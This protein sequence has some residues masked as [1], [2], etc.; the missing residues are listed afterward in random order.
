MLLGSVAD[1]KLGDVGPTRVLLARKRTSD[2]PLIFF[3]KDVFLSSGVQGRVGEYLRVEGVVT[4][5]H[6]K[7]GRDELEI[8][9]ERPGQ[10]AFEEAH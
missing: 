8:I 2:F 10:L 5:Y 3:D 1:I 4:K 9:V 6:T 7:G